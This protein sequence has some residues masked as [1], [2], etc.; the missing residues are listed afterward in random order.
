MLGPPKGRNLDR[1][2]LASLVDFIATF[3]DLP[4]DSRFVADM[5]F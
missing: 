1:P 3:D 2:V 4:R 5:W